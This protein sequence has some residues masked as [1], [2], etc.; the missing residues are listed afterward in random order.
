MIVLNSDDT[1]SS[2]VLNTKVAN[3]H[4]IESHNLNDKFTNES[5]P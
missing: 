3:N 5:T 4:H 1:L 2:F